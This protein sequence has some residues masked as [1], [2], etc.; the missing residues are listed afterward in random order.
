MLMFRNYGV[1]LWAIPD[2][3]VRSVAATDEKRAIWCVRHRQ[4]RGEQAVI[5]QQ[6][7]STTVLQTCTPLIL[8]RIS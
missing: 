2:I 7:A 4:E 8:Q 1:N 5:Y 6:P 3:G